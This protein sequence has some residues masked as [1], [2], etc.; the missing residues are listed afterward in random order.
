MNILAI[1]LLTSSPILF[2]IGLLLYKESPQPEP[3]VGDV[4]H[5][6][7]QGSM[8][9][10]NSITGEP[11]ELV[12]SVNIYRVEEIKDDFVNLV[13]TTTGSDMS[14]FTS[15]KWVELDDLK[16]KKHLYKKMPKAYK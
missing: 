9:N 1:I 14:S 3:K 4:Y 2:L 6:F 8:K 12:S 10:I 13:F 5:S 11:E 15:H 7:F 16:H